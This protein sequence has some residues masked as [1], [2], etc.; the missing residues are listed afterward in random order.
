M[1]IPLNVD[2]DTAKVLCEQNAGFKN[3]H[4]AAIESAEEQE[5]L[6]AYLDSLPGQ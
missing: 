6:L 1:L 3:A 4:L 5:E 2:W